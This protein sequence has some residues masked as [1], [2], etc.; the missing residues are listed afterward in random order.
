[1]YPRGMNAKN[2]ADIRLALDALE[3]INRFS[4]LT[5]IIVVGGDSDFISLAQKVKQANLTII[6]IGVQESTNQFWVQ[7]CNEFK[8]YKTLLGITSGVSTA[9]STERL[10]TVQD[11]PAVSPKVPLA[12]DTKVMGNK[13]N[14]IE[15]DDVNLDDAREL[16]LRAVRHLIAQNG[17]NRVLKARLKPTMVRMDPS[18]DEVNYG[19]PT[20]SSFL[21]AFSDVVTTI[22]ND[23]GGYVQIID[24]QLSITEPLIQSSQEIYERVLKRGKLH[25]LPVP[26]WREALIQAEQIF[27]NAPDKRVPSFEYLEQELGKA[28]EQKGLTNDPALIHRLRG[29]M[30]A[31]WQFRLLNEKGIGLKVE[32]GDGRLLQAIE[33]EMVRR[34]IRHSPPPIDIDSVTS[35]LYGEEGKT[36]TSEVEKIVERAT[37]LHQTYKQA[38]AE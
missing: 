8:Y 11:K 37:A 12:V 32:P 33:E 13:D 24:Q 2:G 18:F 26:W 29:N 30:F 6:G 21:N 16:M 14:A 19:F 4:Y 7:C 27:L 35:I 9:P 34:L 1:M 5:H 20:F 25:I 17:E 23:F 31:L 15:I 3:D 38:E 22:S 10:E 36:K 28:L